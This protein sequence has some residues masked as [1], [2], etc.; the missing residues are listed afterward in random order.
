MMESYLVLKALHIISMV[1]WMA[2]LLYLPRLYVYHAGTQSGSEASEMLKVMEHRLLRY[3]TTPAMIATFVF[4]IW[5]GKVGGMFEPG[6]AGKWFHMKL[7]LVL[8]LAGFHGMLAKWRKDFA[9]D[10][11]TKSAKFFR[12]ANEFPTVILII[13]VFLVVL[14][15]P[16]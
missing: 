13:V 10:R 12:I 4:G 8:L 1:A 3:I 16:Y 15:A 14:K 11:N 2:G 5:M 9:A 7:G 6:A